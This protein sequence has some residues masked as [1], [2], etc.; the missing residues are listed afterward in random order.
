MWEVCVQPEALAPAQTVT[1]RKKPTPA[2][3]PR[4]RKT[5]K[6][7]PMIPAI[8]VMIGACV[9]TRMLELIFRPKERAAGTAALVFATLTIIVAV[10]VIVDLG[11][12]W[13]EC[14]KPDAGT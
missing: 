12:Y 4:D 8:G 5:A 10:V 3:E 14:S 9:I 2:A 11:D 13:L 6:E 7:R 1:M